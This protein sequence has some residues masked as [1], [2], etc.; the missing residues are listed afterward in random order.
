MSTA[1]FYKSKYGAAKECAERISSSLS[2]PSSLYDLNDKHTP[3]LNQ[4]NLIILG[5]SIYVGRADKKVSRFIKNNHNILMK[6]NFGVFVSS[7]SDDELENYLKNTLGDD[8]YNHA[9]F[10]EH[11]GFCYNLDRMKGMDKFI[12]KKMGNI[13][14]NQENFNEDNIDSIIEQSNAL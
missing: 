11:V 13:T 12:V 1:I 5:Y 14:E 8:L 4:Y 10:K 9:V 7:G 2:Q 6:K 3:D